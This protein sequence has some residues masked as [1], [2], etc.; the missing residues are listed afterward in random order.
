MPVAPGLSPVSPTAELRVPGITGEVSANNTVTEVS[1]GISEHLEKVKEGEV[2]TTA[3][4]CTIPVNTTEYV[5]TNSDQSS[6]DSVTECV[7]PSS[8]SSPYSDAV[9]GKVWHLQHTDANSLNCMNKAATKLQSCWRGFYARRHNPKVK[10]VQYE[11]RLSRM[12]EHVVF[13]SQEICRYVL[14]LSNRLKLFR[15]QVMIFFFRTIL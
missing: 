7:P 3:N 15:F 8:A 9:D 1:K 14:L 5:S 2:G 10:E 4:S 13:L 6:C 11:I 12:Q